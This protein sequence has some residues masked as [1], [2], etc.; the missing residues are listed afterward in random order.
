MLRP[1]VPRRR[2]PGRAGPGPFA[3]Q[4]LLE[5][6][7]DGH[8]LPPGLVRRG[9]SCSRRSA[10]R[11]VPGVRARLLARHA[12]TRTSARASTRATIWSAARRGARPTS[13][14][15]APR[16]RAASASS[17]SRRSPRRPNPVVRHAGPRVE[18]RDPLLASASSRS[19]RGTIELASRAS[20]RSSTHLVSRARPPVRAIVYDNTG[21]GYVVGVRDAHQVQARRALLRLARV[22]ALAQRAHATG[23]ASARAPLPVRSDAHPD[24]ARQLP[25]RPRLGVRRALPPRLRATRDTPTSTRLRRSSPALYAARRRQPTP[26]IPGSAL[27]RALPLFHQLDLRVDKRWQFAAWQ[28]STYLDVQNVYNNAARRGRQLQLQ[29]QRAQLPD[30]APIIPSLGC[31]RG[32]L[33]SSAM[34]RATRWQLRRSMTAVGARRCAWPALSAAAARNSIRAASFMTRARARRGKERPLRPARRPRRPAAALARYG[35]RAIPRPEIGAGQLADAGTRT[36]A[37]GQR[38]F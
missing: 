27:Q 13:D 1:R 26:P 3:T 36:E 2:A 18:P 24:G 16:S 19:S 10:L 21:T 6:S 17:T 32:V 20:T 5:T 11:I 30:R 25:P 31:A 38:C 14:A 35:P 12:G 33:S 4:P 9:A 8:A 15:R 28:L 22:H 34:P 7:R 37:S 29:L 23:P